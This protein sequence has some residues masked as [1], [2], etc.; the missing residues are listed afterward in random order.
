MCSNHLL[1]LAV[2]KDFHPVI[3]ISL[4]KMHCLICRLMIVKVMCQKLIAFK[5]IYVMCVQQSRFV[6]I[7]LL[8]Y[9]KFDH[10]LMFQEQ[11]I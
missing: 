7:F 6:L 10:R 9:S 4:I 3:K 2:R 11:A 1:F 5:G 8:V